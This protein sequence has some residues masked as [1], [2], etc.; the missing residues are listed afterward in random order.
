[1]TIF[2]QEAVSHPF[3]CSVAF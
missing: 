3:W 1:V 2:E